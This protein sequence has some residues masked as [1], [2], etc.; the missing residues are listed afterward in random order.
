MGKTK[1]ALLMLALFL[2]GNAMAEVTNGK[3]PMCQSYAEMQ[4]I[5]SGLR[6]N[7]DR[8]VQAL[9]QGD[10]CFYPK[11]GFKL[12]VIRR[13]GELDRVRVYLDDNDSLQLYTISYGYD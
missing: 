4:E 13:V 2:S 11:K 12:S 8:Q 6:K 3:Y 5:I 10:R 7:D 9:L 1:V